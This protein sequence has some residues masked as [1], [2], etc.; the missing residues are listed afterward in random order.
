MTRPYL[1]AN[2]DDVAIKPEPKPTVRRAARYNRA[3]DRYKVYLAG[4][5]YKPKKDEDPFRSM[6]FECQGYMTIGEL[7]HIAD[8]NRIHL[9]FISVQLVTVAQSL[10]PYVPVRLRKK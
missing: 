10:R 5:L 9:N 4:K 8:K 3:T 1:P 2:L 6:T 7:Q